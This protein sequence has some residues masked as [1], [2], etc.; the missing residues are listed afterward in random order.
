MILKDLLIQTTFDEIVQTVES[1][2][3]SFGIEV[4]DD[5]KRQWKQMFNSLCE[6]E[7]SQDV[8]RILM[9]ISDNLYELYK[10]LNPEGT[11]SNEHASFPFARFS[12]GG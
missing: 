12:C 3:V 4:T 9:G 2:Y 6:M 5:R 8:D 10:E 11:T 7:P 1:D